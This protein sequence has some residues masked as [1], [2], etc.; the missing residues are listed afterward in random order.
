M[1]ATLLSSSRESYSDDWAY[2]VRDTARGHVDSLRLRPPWRGVLRASANANAKSAATI[3][4]KDGKGGR[5]WYARRERHRAPRGRMSY[6]LVAGPF[7]E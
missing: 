2:V 6:A 7:E 4:R 3:N 5:D 1:A